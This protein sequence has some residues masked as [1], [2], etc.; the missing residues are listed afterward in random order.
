MVK[1]KKQIKKKSKQKNVLNMVE[2]LNQALFQEMNQD[3]DV[4]ILGEDVGLDGGVFRVSD[5]L[6]KKYGKERVIDTPL[7]ESGIVGFSIG[8]AAAG[9]KPI[10]EIQFS[11]F[12]YPA[13]NQII[14]HAS[15]LRNRTR[16][17]Y[18]CP[19]VIRAPCGGGIRAL[20]HHSESME[21]IFI[22]TPGI[23]VVMPST[24]SD[25]K[26]L[27]I[28]AIRD[29]DPVIFY[30]PKR[31][32]RSIKEDIPKESYEIP[33]GKARI[34]REGT[35]VSI[36]TWGSVVKDC[37]EVADSL[38][39]KVSVEVI[40][41]RTLKPLDIETVIESVKKTGRVVIV[42]EAP[43]TSGFG[44]ELI[45]LI[46]EKALLDLQA[47]VIRVTGFD[48]IFPL[49]KLEKHY[50]PNHDRIMKGINDVLNY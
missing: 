13:V 49:Y 31:V 48:T 43:K 8:M 21:N 35:D 19:L 17:A 41:L 23:K 18:T 37:N 7:A 34:S 11:G 39:E 15:R 47:P 46:N 14:S 5:G 26:G 44:A 3:E 25:A 6:Q 33:L 50:M 4:V 10:A 27:L 12:L 42:H 30:E 9:L 16:G 22:H 32:Y 29:P 45:A 28:S 40:D 2:A 1:K 20:E 24:P 36:L 38:K